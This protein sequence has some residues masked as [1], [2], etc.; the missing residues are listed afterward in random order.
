M[1]IMAPASYVKADEIATVD[2]LIRQ[3]APRFPDSMVGL[4]CGAGAALCWAAGFTVARRGILIG[5]SP[6]DL[7]LHRFAWAGFF[8]LP[9]VMR[10]GCVD[11]GGIGW[12]RGILLTLFG[13]PPMALISYAGFILVPLGHGGVIQPSSATLFGLLLSALVLKEW[14]PA[15][16]LVGAGVIIVG[17]CLIGIEALA[18][19]GRHGLLG[20]LA[21]LVAGLCFAI[22]AVLLRLWRI[23][24]LPALGVVAVLSLADFAVH[25]ALF[26]FARMLSLGLWE[27]LLQVVAQGIFAGPVA[28][29]LFARAVVLVGPARA[30]VFS[31]L[32]PALTLA[33]GYVLIGEVP[34]VMQLV[35]MLIVLAGFRLTQ[36]G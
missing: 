6:A 19:I 22:F 33:I 28:I 12:R 25:A 32:V 23:A 30:A 29:Y 31:S 18:T 24:P 10:L 20:D 17:V 26:G 15:A 8:F 13:G 16:R 7:A 14:L 3:F 21:F 4:A 1:V 36:R 5:F 9:Y 11:L 27:N 34:S 2:P 35:G